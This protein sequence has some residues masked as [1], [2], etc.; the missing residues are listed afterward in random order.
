MDRVKR[1]YSYLSQFQHATIRIRTEEPDL[2]SL[3]NQVFDQEK[4]IYREVTE[5]L[6][7]D[8]PQKC[9]KSASTISYY[10]TNNLYHNIIT[11]RSAIGVL[12]LLNKTP[13]NT[14]LL[15]LAQNRFQILDILFDTQVFLSRL[16]ALCLEIISLQWVVL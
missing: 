9:G 4:S 12:Y 5:L 13:I 7:K 10:N 15:E 8:T 16:R 2:S 6:P 1:I 14:L 3:P 11:G